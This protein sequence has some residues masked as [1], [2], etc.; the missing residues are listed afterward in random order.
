MMEQVLYR[1]VDDRPVQSKDVIAAWCMWDH[2]TRIQDN[3]MSEQYGDMFRQ[4]AGEWELCNI[5]EVEE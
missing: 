5:S 4:I 2:Y 1:T 3:E